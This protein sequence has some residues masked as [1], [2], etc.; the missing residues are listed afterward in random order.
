MACMGVRCPQVAYHARRNSRVLEYKVVQSA[1]SLRL[2]I[3]ILKTKKRR[4]ICL[5]LLHVSCW[6]SILQTYDY[7]SPGK[8]RIP[9]SQCSNTRTSV[10]GHTLRYYLQC[11][12]LQRTILIASYC[13][14]TL[15]E[16]A[17][18][19]SQLLHTHACQ[20]VIVTFNSP[21]N[22]RLLVGLDAMMRQ[23]YRCIY[24]STRPKNIIDNKQSSRPQLHTIKSSTFN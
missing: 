17:H 13:I 20:I 23:A 11:P 3:L 10:N 4:K 6:L 9:K 12:S 21:C 15:Q 19:H 2:R 18:I 24:D 1:Q 8:N 16:I 22:S 5:I 7:H 14:I